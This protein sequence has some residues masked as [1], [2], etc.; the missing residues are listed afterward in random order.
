MFGVAITL[1]KNCSLYGSAGITGATTA[2]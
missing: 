2:F 1:N